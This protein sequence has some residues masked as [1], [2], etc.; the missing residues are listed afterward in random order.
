MIES[1]SNKIGSPFVIPVINSS[2][3]DTRK[4]ACIE[5]ACK[6]INQIEGNHLNGDSCIMK[7]KDNC[8]NNLNKTVTFN[9]NNNNFNFDIDYEDSFCLADDIFDFDNSNYYQNESEFN[10]F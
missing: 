5:N 8:I 10:V 4:S 6:Q 9:N 2:E 7:N 1:I 3:S